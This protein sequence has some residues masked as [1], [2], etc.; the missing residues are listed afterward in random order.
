MNRAR[1]AGADAAAE[2]GPGQAEQ[3]AQRPEQR[4]RR[5]AR[6][7]G[8]WRGAPLTKIS[9]AASKNGEKEK[10]GDCGGSESPGREAFLARIDLGQNDARRRWSRAPPLCRKPRC[11][12]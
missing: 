7:S 10:E 5:V 2:L 8:S 6:S 1:A 4:Q 9:I 3:V 11:L 12:E